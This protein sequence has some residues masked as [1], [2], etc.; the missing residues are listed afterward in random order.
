MN[1]F[2]DYINV[3]LK[4]HNG[5]R[6]HRCAHH[7]KLT[8]WMVQKAHSPPPKHAQ[9]SQFLLHE[10]QISPPNYSLETNEICIVYSE[11]PG[12]GSV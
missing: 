7:P 6:L 5:M 8:G 2:T 12:Y 1:I 9:Q 11:Q 10:P 4:K 3:D